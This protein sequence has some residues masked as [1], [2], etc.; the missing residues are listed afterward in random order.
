MEQYLLDFFFLKTLRDEKQSKKPLFF[1]NI[2]KFSWTQWV[3]FDLIEAERL[4]FLKRNTIIIHELY[5]IWNLKLE[6]LRVKLPIVLGLSDDRL[7]EFYRNATDFLGNLNARVFYLPW[8]HF[9]RLTENSI[10]WAQFKKYARELTGI[11]EN[12]ILMWWMSNDT[13]KFKHLTKEYLDGIKVLCY[14]MIWPSQSAVSLNIHFSWDIL[15][16][17]KTW[18]EY[19]EEFEYQEW[20]MMRLNAYSRVDIEVLELQDD[21]IF[22]QY[23]IFRPK[24]FHIFFNQQRFIMWRRKYIGIF[25]SLVVFYEIFYCPGEYLYNIW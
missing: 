4:K 16:Y 20:Y 14:D 25:C 11:K 12:E 22:M 1:F 8:N 10:I 19:A 9:Y 17:H 2:A 18:E 24:L 23:Q 6:P 7:K 3:G 13:E 15:Q 5:S 21:F